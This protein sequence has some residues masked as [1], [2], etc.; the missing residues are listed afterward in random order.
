MTAELLRRAA[1]RL[2]QVARGDTYVRV[3]PGRPHEPEIIEVDVIRDVS[4]DGKTVGVEVVKAIEVTVDGVRFGPQVAAP[5]AA[6]LRNTA[7]WASS[8]E[9]C[10]Y[11]EAEELARV[12]LGEEA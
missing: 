7:D 11:V 10:P 6:W 1:D 12:I 2:D 9:P 4:A 8:G 3:R 5:L